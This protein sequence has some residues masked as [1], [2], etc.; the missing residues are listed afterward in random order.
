MVS[1]LR[2]IDTKGIC[3][4]VQI[5]DPTMTRYYHNVRVFVRPLPG[6]KEDY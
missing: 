5:S 1:R 2:K 3:M 4:R 6:Q